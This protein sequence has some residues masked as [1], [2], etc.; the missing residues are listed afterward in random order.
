MKIKMILIAGL[1]TIAGCS[2]VTKENYQL[3]EVGMDYQKTEELLGAPAN[4]EE[5]LG[6]KQ[7]TWGSEQKNIE[8]K[9]IADKVTIYSN[10]GL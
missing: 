1:L 7:C 8:I 6:I 3:L 4:C 5:T 2:K 9:F 10:K